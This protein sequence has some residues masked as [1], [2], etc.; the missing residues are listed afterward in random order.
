MPGRKRKIAVVTVGRSDYGVYRSVLRALADRGDVDYGLV[1]SGDHPLNV[2][3]GDARNGPGQDGHPVWAE[4]QMAVA[5]DSDRSAA[6]SMGLGGV[7][8]AE[9]WARLHP[10]IVLILG[11]RF[12]MFAAASALTPYRIALAHLHGGEITEGAVDERF[13]HALTKLSHL[14]LVATP[15]AGRRVEQMGEEPWRVTVTGAPGLD[16]FFDPAPL[17]RA[18]LMAGL[19]I[20]DPGPYLLATYHPVTNGSGADAQGLDALLRALDIVR[21]PVWFTAANADPGGQRVNAQVRAW[22]AARPDRALFVPTLGDFYG[23][24]MAHA[25]AMVGNSS[26]GVIEACS[27]DLPVVNIG[28]RQQGRDR[29][30]NLVDVPA[31]TTAIVRAIR[32]AVSPEGRARARA[33]VNIYGSGGAGARVAERLAAVPIDDRLFVKSFQTWPRPS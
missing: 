28:S 33:A 26:S 2:E 7:Q 12:E 6:L 1:V 19:G 14:H 21:L 31:D 15:Q 22:V 23:P 4:L 30:D 13:R 27:A 16:A 29:S 32:S 25:A 17:T 8:F 10:D 20:Q 5:G 3:R 18:A 11:D 24:A 9:A